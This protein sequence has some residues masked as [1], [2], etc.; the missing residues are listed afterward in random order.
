M[1]SLPETQI[2]KLELLTEG[3]EF[4]FL[5]L[6]LL[7]MHFFIMFS[8]SHVLMRGHVGGGAKNKEKP[9]NDSVEAQSWTGALKPE[10]YR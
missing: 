3:E 8:K 4:S 10:V 6:F 9:L 5:S 2:E 1:I 7:R